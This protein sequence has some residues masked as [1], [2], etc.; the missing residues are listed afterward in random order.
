MLITSLVM[1][2][3]PN[4][5]HMGTSPAD[6]PSTVN[7][8]ASMASQRLRDATNSSRDTAPRTVMSTLEF[9]ERLWMV[10]SKFGGGTEIQALRVR[11]VLREGG[12]EIM[13]GRGKCGARVVR[14]AMASPPRLRVPS[15]ILCDARLF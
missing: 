7:H 5:S 11:V 6:D 14:A 13:V 12:T 1:R 8:T 9:L 15:A 10:T 2:W 3:L 4:A